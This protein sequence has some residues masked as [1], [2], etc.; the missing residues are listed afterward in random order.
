MAPRD[1]NLAL[2]V[3]S[4]L[5]LAPL[6]VGAAYLGGWPF[7]VFW[8]VAAI[9]ILWEWM[10][11]VSR[12]FDWHAFL[13][14]TCTILASGAL[15]AIGRPVVGLFIIALGALGAAAVGALRHPAWIAGGVAY[16]GVMAAAPIRLRDDDEMGFL[17]ILF[18]FAIVWSTDIVG[19]FAGRAFGGPKLAPSVSPKKTWSGAVAGAVAA[20]LAATVVASYAG[21][22]VGVPLIAVAFILS[23]VA[24]LGDLMESKIKRKFDAK[25]ASKLLPGHGG[26]M[27]RLDG[28]W[29]AA[30][31]A[32]FLGALRAGFDTAG[33]GLLVW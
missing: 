32:T 23:A 29:A 5:V 12:P 25:D 15:V 24:Q 31:A 14:G 2:R 1:H 17:A 18:L 26:L 13:T 27:D 19:Y 3:A 8:S 21:L 11:L 7:I 9:G 33:H 22:R 4:A 20:V 28:F 30:V 16:A 10:R 6:A